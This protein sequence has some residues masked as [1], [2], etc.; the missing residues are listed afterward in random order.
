MNLLLGAITE[1]FIFAPLALGLYLSY[2][3]YDILDLTVDGSFGVGAA[4]V[5]AL[6]VR[7]VPPV[8]ATL[9]GAFA[10]AGGG[11]ITG[12]ICTRLRVN[13]SL[14]GVLITTGLYSVILFM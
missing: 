6:L 1:G 3:V 11:S 7:G 2:R 14:A 10:G 9:L 13:A 4:A 8:E 12:V 5:A